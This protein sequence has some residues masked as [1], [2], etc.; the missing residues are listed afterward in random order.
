[1]WEKLRLVSDMSYLKDFLDVWNMQFLPGTPEIRE[2]VRLKL[3]SMAAE[4]PGAD[5]I[6][7]PAQGQF[8]RALALDMGTRMCANNDLVG[9]LN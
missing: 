9:K 8:C 6:Q 5:A 3:S 2:N 1:M 7:V 4:F